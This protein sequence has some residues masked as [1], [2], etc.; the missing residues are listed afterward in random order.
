M[1]VGKMELTVCKLCE[2]GKGFSRLDTHLRKKHKTTPDEYY[3]QFPEEKD[4]PTMIVVEEEEFNGIPEQID[5]P[6]E[7]KSATTQK[8]IREKL[9]GVPFSGA[10][11]PLQ[12]LLDEFEIT[13]RELR[14]IVRQYKTGSAMTALEQ[15]ERKAELGKMEAIKLSGS[16]HVETTKLETAVSLKK[17]HGYT[18]VKV[19]SGP[20]KTWV[21]IKN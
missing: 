5:E 14:Q 12:E 9:F 21:L 3:L 17:E 4:N 7:E 6:K 10:D 16:G 19:K 18:V 13:E 1:E 2:D 15:V 8:E 20:P 11:R